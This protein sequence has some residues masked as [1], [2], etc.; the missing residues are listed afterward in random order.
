MFL[1]QSSAADVHWQ[2]FS[3]VFGIPQSSHVSW[4][5]QFKLDLILLGTM[6][7]S[8]LTS[9]EQ[10]YRSLFPG[11]YY[12]NI[13]CFQSLVTSHVYMTLGIRQLAMFAYKNRQVV[14]IRIRVSHVE[15]VV[16]TGSLNGVGGA[17]RFSCGWHH[18]LRGKTTTGSALDGAEFDIAQILAYLVHNMSRSQS[19]L[20][21]G[22]FGWL[23]FFRSI[24]FWWAY[25]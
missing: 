13:S 17:V 22:H 21:F 15:A 14:Q 2:Y 9:I 10:W 18:Q 12:C 3:F 23:P 24:T 1:Q 8:Q 7:C 16:Y 5:W 25:G 19:Y 11:V 4:Q 20:G 6:S